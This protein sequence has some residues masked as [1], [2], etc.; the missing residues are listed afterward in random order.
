MILTISLE[1]NLNI[2]TG[3]YTS[4]MR[5]SLKQIMDK[6]EIDIGLRRLVKKLWDH[7][8]KTIQS[9]AG[10]GK[11]A[12]VMVLD[13]DG[14]F[15]SNSYKWGLKKYENGDCCTM[16]IEEIQKECNF[17]RRKIADKGRTCICCGAGINGYSIYRGYLV[18]PS[19]RS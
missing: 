13:G 5:E 10:H 12:Y 3:V 15:E 17:N 19:A 2:D 16:V 9:C 7:K 4:K 18:Q 6:L 11:E 1:K 14:W 8:Y